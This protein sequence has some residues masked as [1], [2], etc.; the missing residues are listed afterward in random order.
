MSTTIRCA[1]FLAPEPLM[2]ST[3][4][5]RFAAADACFSDSPAST[6]TAWRTFVLRQPP[7][8]FGTSST[9]IRRC[10]SSRASP[11]EFVKR[12]SKQSWPPAAVAPSTAQRRLPISPPVRPGN[13]ETPRP[14]ILNAGLSQCPRRRAPAARS[15]PTPSLWTIQAT[16]KS[17][18]TPRSI[19]PSQSAIRPLPTV[20]RAA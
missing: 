12:G 16:K 19:P 15:R 6:S 4:Q 7:L 1:L 13:P 11:N 10:R 2:G 9:R 8:L 20:C 3:V 5:T 18:W 17:S 14:A